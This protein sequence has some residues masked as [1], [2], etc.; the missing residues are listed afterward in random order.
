MATKNTS[1]TP[2]QIRFET[3]RSLIRDGEQLGD[4]VMTTCVEALEA[5]T[6][7]GAVG[8]L[9]GVENAIKSLQKIYDAVMALHQT[10][11]R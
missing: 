6:Q 1:L 8:T 10:G 7:N 3:I 11:A 5:D 2:A 9:M 4:M